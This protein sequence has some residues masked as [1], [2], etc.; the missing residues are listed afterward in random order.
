[1][2]ASH[3]KLSVYGGDRWFRLAQTVVLRDE[4]G[5][6]D[7]DTMKVD[8]EKDE[9]V[10]QDRGV[11]KGTQP[12]NWA[13][14][15]AITKGK[16]ILSVDALTVEKPMEVVESSKQ[17]L[18]VTDQKRRRIEEEARPS[19]VGSSSL[20]NQEKEIDNY[21]QSKPMVGLGSR[22]TESHDILE[23]I[24]SHDVLKLELSWA[25]QSTYSLSY[26]RSYS[27]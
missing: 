3:R 19:E 14:V 8:T 11:H 25:W 12:S 24:E 21:V 26:E 5:V 17:G 10:E 7:I 15:R 4:E 23:P 20:L 9:I 22:P 13:S 18:I 27:L 2:R 1:M 16:E 6:N